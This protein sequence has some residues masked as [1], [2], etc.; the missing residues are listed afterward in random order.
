MNDYAW[1][2]GRRI[3]AA[4]NHL[5]RLYGT[6]IQKLT[7]DAGFTCPNRD[8]TKGTGGCAYCNNDAFN[9]SYCSPEKSVTQ[10]I[11]EG[12]EFHGKRYRRAKKYVAYFQ[13]YSNTYNDLPELKKLY[14]EALKNKEVVG[15][16][17]GTRPDC[18]AREKLEYLAG[19]AEKYY[20]VVEYGI[21]SVYDRTLERI[22]RGHT[23]RD[24]VEAVKLTA[25]YGIHSGAH[26]IFGLPGESREEMLTSVSEVSRLPL[27]SIKLHQL[28]ILKGSRFA[29][30]YV[31]NAS[32]FQLFD[33]E[34][35]VD[36]IT[37][38]LSRLNPEFLIDRLAAETQPRYCLSYN[39]DLRYDRV[40]KL[41]EKRM[42]EKDY[43]QG[44]FFTGT[45]TN[46]GK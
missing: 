32:A 9:P 18:I 15:L 22:N 33:L 37:E 20:I 41:I 2:T 25:Q 19:L 13:A 8:G 24:S 5:R 45:E 1:G 44:K 27:Y 42:E 11:G 38:Y 36:F 12:I 7:I 14:G 10:Q 4:S 35:Y 40:L 29:S 17:I 43:W 3:N 21:E 39:W 16:I 34:E 30:E 46:Y 31:E 6:R 23:Y 28:Q 26:F